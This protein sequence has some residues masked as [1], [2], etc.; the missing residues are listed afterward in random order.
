MSF[1]L[2]ALI[3]LVTAF[4]IF[5]ACRKG[6]KWDRAECRAAFRYFTVQS[7]A[8]CAFSA[9]LM[10]AAPASRFVWMLKYVGTAAVTVTLF[11]V[12]LFLAPSLGSLRPLLK[13]DN[14]FMHLL[15]PLAAIV[16]FC[17]FEKRGLSFVS[18]LWGM[19][20]VV[21]YGLLYL[22]KI[23]YAPA[24]RRWEDFYGFNKGG[25]WPAAFITMMAG[26]FAVCMEL[27]A[28]QN[29]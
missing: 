13:G 7:N 6:G 16:S 1:I 8:F 17:F 11:T 29:L 10:C 14:L 27:M 3:F 2:N 12:F 9:L 15:T 22:Y 21:L 18:A 23:I 28:L 4:L 20:P 24:D 26:A 25:K 5:R 19:L